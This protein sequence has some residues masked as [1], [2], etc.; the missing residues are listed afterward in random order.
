MAGGTNVGG[1]SRRRLAVA[2]AMILLAASATTSRAGVFHEYSVARDN[3][4]AGTYSAIQLLRPDADYQVTPGSN[5]N[6][7]YA[8]GSNPL[9]Q[10]QWVILSYSNGLDWIELGTGHQCNDFHYRFHGYGIDGSWFPKPAVQI[11]PPIANT[12][13]RIDSQGGCSWRWY[14][15]GVQQ[16]STYA[17]CRRG[18]SVEGG[19]E[20]YD[21]GGGFGWLRYKDLKHRISTGGLTFWAG[22]DSHTIS[23]NMGGQWISATEWRAWQP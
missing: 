2:M 14:I 22:M 18:V 13:Y 19:L 20:S 12:N 23:P 10:T 15:A 9:Y 1:H 8:G 6:V 5:C 16:T 17:D 3:S 4:Q 21:S 7:P 11:S